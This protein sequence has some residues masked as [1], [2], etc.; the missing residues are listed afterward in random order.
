MKAITIQ[1]CFGDLFIQ[2]ALIKSLLHV[3]HSVS[4]L[5]IG[6]LYELDM[7]AN[8]RLFTLFLYQKHTPKKPHNGYKFKW[9][10]T[11]NASWSSQFSSKITEI[12][13][14][15]HFGFP[16]ETRVG[17]PGECP[18]A[19]QPWTRWNVP[20]PSLRPSM[21]RTP[22]DIWALALGF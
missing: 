8:H 15:V 10:P 2:K 14:I 1:R 12:S 7:A 21:L 16:H 4:Y 3:R 22:Q 20:H 13:L 9:E 18:T 19:P 11:I 17:K 5:E 6:Q